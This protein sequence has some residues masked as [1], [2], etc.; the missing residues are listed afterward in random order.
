MLIKED[1]RIRESFFICM[2]TYSG[3][4]GPGSTICGDEGNAEHS[5]RDSAEKTPKF[6]GFC[7]FWTAKNTQKKFK[8]SLAF[9]MQYV[10]NSKAC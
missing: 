8:K 5:V 3:K 1:S 9:H 10:Y 4:S 2:P 7:T 6:Q